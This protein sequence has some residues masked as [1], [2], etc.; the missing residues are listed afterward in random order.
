VVVV[1]TPAPPPVVVV[2]RPRVAVL[3]FV[4]LGDPALV[5][6]GLGAWAA[7]QFAPYLCPPYDGTD[8]GELYWYMGRLG[9]TLR[10]AVIDPLARL[11]LGRAL[12]ARFVVLGTLRATPAGLEVT[13]H[14]LDT[15]TGARLSTVGALVRDQYEL[16]CRLGEMA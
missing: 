12:N 4:T 2:T 1:E 3:D 8:R 5:P 9:L 10:D 6:P 11:Y 15:E 13:T 16:K 14:L 7:E